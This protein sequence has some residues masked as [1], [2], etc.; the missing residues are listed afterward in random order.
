MASFEDPFTLWGEGID[1]DQSFQFE[2]SSSKFKA[3]AQEFFGLGSRYEKVARAYYEYSTLMD[4]YSQIEMGRKDIGV[5]EFDQA[6][7]KFDESAK[8]LRS[9]IHFGFLAPFIS[10]CATT[11]TTDKMEREDA[12]CLQGYKNAIAFYEQSKLALS[13]RDERHSIITVI[14]AGIRYCISQALFVESLDQRRQGNIEASADKEKRSKLLRSEFEGLLKKA[15]RDKKSLIYHPLD[16]YE[17]AKGSAFV[18]SF[19]DASS[20]SL[21]NLGS[22]TARIEKIGNYEPLGADLEPSNSMNFSSKVIGKGKIRV[23]Y[24]DMV[25]GKKFNEGCLMAI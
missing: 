9:T 18:V 5:N 20:L 21:L 25:C 7:V 14:D 19:P 2:E 22:N 13:F 23:I 12:E 6:L 11:E 1:L 10:A 16:D 3:A 17:R 4:A 15:G 8:I 24:T